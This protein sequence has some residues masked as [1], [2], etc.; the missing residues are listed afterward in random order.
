MDFTPAEQKDYF[1]TNFDRSRI[2]TP[3][4]KYSPPPSKKGASPSK[5]E[6]MEVDKSPEQREVS[7]DRKYTS[8]ITQ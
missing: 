1:K 6:D 2:P 4:S 3:G 8:D 7:G 5:D